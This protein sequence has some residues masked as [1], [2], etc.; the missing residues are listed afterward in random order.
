M[1]VLL[2]NVETLDGLNFFVK[3]AKDIDVLFFFSH[4]V[5][6][7]LLASIAGPLAQFINYNPR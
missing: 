7:V 4:A 2:P 3:A 6:L 5:F 1:E